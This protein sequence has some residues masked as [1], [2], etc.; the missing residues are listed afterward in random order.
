VVVTSPC[1]P[2]LIFRAQDNRNFYVFNLSGNGRT[3][4]QILRDGEWSQAVEGKNFKPAKLSH[5]RADIQDISFVIFINGS[6]V[7]SLQDAT[8][9]NGK[10][11]LRILGDKE[12]AFDNFK[13]TALK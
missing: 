12:V 1:Y 11:G 7:F 9:R 8:F 4:F 3:N 6:E 13:V 2:T 5:I 10:A